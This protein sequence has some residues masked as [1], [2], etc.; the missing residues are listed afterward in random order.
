MDIFE[1]MKTSGMAPVPVFCSFPLFVCFWKRTVP[2][3]LDLPAH[4]C[5]FHVWIMARP[6]IGHNLGLYGLVELAGSYVTG[7]GLGIGLVAVQGIEQ[8]SPKSFIMLLINK[9]GVN[10]N[11]H[12]QLIMLD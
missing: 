7:L 4:L 11:S 5:I 10:I 2:K 8:G 3:L 1:T 6:S 9:T 12:L